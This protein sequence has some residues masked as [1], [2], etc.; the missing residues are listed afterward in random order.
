MVD[1]WEGMSYAFR[2][3]ASRVA[4]NSKHLAFRS[5]L[6]TYFSTWSNASHE[7]QPVSTGL[8]ETG[9]SHQKGVNALVGQWL[10]HPRRKRRD[11]A[12]TL[13]SKVF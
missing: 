9:F 11:Y 5:S 3:D 13:E 8:P 6:A 4:F 12:K 2:R 10:T 7:P 1:R